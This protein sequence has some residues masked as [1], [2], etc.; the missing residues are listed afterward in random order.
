MVPV[1]CGESIST[2]F[3]RVAQGPTAIHFKFLSCPHLVHRIPPVIRTS[4]E[5]STALCTT[6]PQVTR[7]SSE[8]TTDDRSFVFTPSFPDNSPLISNSRVTLARCRPRPPQADHRPRSRPNGMKSRFQCVLTHWM[9]GF[10]T[11]GSGPPYP[12]R[13]ESPQ[14]PIGN[15]AP[16]PGGPGTASRNVPEN[17]IAPVSAPG[18][19]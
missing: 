2:P 11:S 12:H 16:W 13:P 14:P 6:T 17:T 10:R 7:R 1:S 9:S 18:L 5:L 15:R 8:N 3:A 19:P 4:R